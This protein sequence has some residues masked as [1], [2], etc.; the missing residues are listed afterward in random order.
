M[1]TSETSEEKPRPTSAERAALQRS[2]PPEEGQVGRGDEADRAEEGQRRLQ[3]FSAI[4]AYL[5]K[6]KRK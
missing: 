1:S 6:K 3:V 5:A 2:F 4:G